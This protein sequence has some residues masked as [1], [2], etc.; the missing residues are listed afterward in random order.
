MMIRECLD[1]DYKDIYRLN[2]NAFGYDYD[3]EKTKI[4]LN[5]IINRTTD[6]I[7]VACIDNKVVGYIHG[8]DYECT[9]SESLKNIMAIAVDEN[10]RGKGIGRALLSAIENWAKETNC[11][12]VRLVSGFNRAEAHKFYLCCGYTVRK[13]QKNFIKY[14]DK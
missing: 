9:Y 8:S 11:C 6:R 1:R 3:I 4:R 13:D 14:F 7:Y 5:K 12:G 2:L 10:Y